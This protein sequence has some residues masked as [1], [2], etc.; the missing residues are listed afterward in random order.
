MTKDSVTARKNELE[1]QRLQ[2]LANLNAVAGA[3]QDCDYWLAQLEEEER[4]KAQGVAV[5]VL[6]P[7]I[8]IE[9]TPVS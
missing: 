9:A 5:E 3:M 8:T 4:Q 1:Q 6:P 2:F 7:A